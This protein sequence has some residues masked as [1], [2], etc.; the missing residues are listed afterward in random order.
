MDINKH[1]DLHHDVCAPT[2][3][4]PSNQT[5]VPLTHVSDSCFF[6]NLCPRGPAFL[7]GETE[8]TQSQQYG[9]L[10]VTWN[11]GPCTLPKPETT[12]H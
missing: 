12:N 10:K 6:S 9:H 5:P 7:P 4:R 11:K 2:V 1:S 3:Q 8:D